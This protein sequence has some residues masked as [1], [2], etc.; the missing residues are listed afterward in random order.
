[1]SKKEKNCIPYSNS[2]DERTFSVLKRVK[3]YLRS[4][5]AN[6]KKNHIYHSCVWNLK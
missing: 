4:S 5:V 3:T 1:M 6:E 2:S